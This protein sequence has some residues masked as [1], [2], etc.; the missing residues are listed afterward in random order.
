MRTNILID[1]S[2]HNYHREDHNRP[3]HLRCIWIRACREE[4]HHEAHNEEC[5]RYVV[6]EAAPFAQRPAARE[7]W[8]VVGALEAY[9]ADGGVLNLTRVKHLVMYATR[10]STAL[11]LHLAPKL[12]RDNDPVMTGRTWDRSTPC[13]AC[14]PGIV[15]IL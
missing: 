14:F 10:L 15:C 6:D 12:H 5:Q 1:S 8:L 11:M 4:T 9:T 2:R 7:Q 3:I 13:A